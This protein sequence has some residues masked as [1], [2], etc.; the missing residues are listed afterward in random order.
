MRHVRSN[1]KRVAKQQ[2][3]NKR[4]LLLT[5][6]GRMHHT[7]VSS[8]SCSKQKLKGLKIYR[9]KHQIGHGPD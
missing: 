4:N 8:E 3:S 5:G 9:E 2:F 7:G 6:K 1:I